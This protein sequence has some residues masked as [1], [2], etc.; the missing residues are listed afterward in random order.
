[1]IEAVGDE[2]AER[3]CGLSMVRAMLCDVCM[4]MCC[5]TCVHVCVV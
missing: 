2:S 4:C 3:T 1:M 5:V